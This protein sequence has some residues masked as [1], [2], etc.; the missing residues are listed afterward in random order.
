MQTCEGMIVRFLNYFCLSSNILFATMSN[1][2]EDKSARKDEDNSASKVDE[3]RLC[4]AQ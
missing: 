4:E 2:N 1:H 3:A